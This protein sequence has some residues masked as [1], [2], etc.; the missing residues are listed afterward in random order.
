MTKFQKQIVTEYT[1]ISI[2]NTKE[3]KYYKLFLHNGIYYI[4]VHENDNFAIELE[5]KASRFQMYPIFTSGANIYQA[6]T[7][8]TASNP[9]DCGPDDSWELQPA[10]TML[11]K[12]F[13]NPDDQSGRN[14]VVSHFS[15]GLSIA[16][17]LFDDQSLQGS[18]RIF[19][20]LAKPSSGS[21]SGSRSSESWG[22]SIGL[23]ATRSMGSER[24][25]TKSLGGASIG[26]GETNHSNSYTTGINYEN[27]V[28]DLAHIEIVYYDELFQQILTPY[29]GLEYGISRFVEPNEFRPLTDRIPTSP[30]PKPFRG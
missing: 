12:G 11:V 9:K 21:K 18:L 22:A 4:A 3:N 15:K 1:N 5:N 8:Q 6:T 23:G 25:V 17:N 14:F 20:K 16:E 10:Q 13:H 28:F 29:Y 30:T 24:S 19:S 7:Y 2:K 26:L 27:R